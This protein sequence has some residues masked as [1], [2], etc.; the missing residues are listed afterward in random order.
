MRLEL[1]E[2]QVAIRDGLERLFADV[3]READPAQAK[4]RL[5]RHLAEMGWLSLSASIERGGS[6]NASLEVGL[7]MRAA[8][9]HALVTPYFSSLAL[10]GGVMG[11][12][13]ELDFASERFAR[14]VEGK[15]RLALAH[16]EGDDFDPASPSVTAARV[17]GAWKLSGAK[18]LSFGAADADWLIVSASLAPD[19]LFG[20]F[21][22]PATAAGVRCK[23]VGT[24]RG[25]D[26]ADLVLDVTAPTD[27]CLLQ[28]PRAKTLLSRVIDMATLAL[29]WEAVG[30]M[31]SLFEQTAAYVK[32]REQFGQP[33][34]V[35][36][37][38]QH[39][40]AEMAVLCEE[41]QSI[42]ELASLQAATDQRRRF[43]SAAKVRIAHGARF[44]AET[45]VQLHGG[46]GVT[47]ELPVARY[48]RILLGFQVALG[49]SDQ[50]LGRYAA[51]TLSTKAHTKSAVLG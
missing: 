21:L 23:R 25:E 26:A 18:D 37:T 2:D 10:G 6:P 19:G 41:A 43:T 5:W 1:S 40:L 49:T 46:V 13:S 50:H 27:A 12:L 33:I 24:L 29:C 34:A 31:V 32:I 9:R 44:V 38:V 51:E 30:A 17:D 3:A 39:R 15:E 42:A 20:L 35:F 48:F 11:A 4:A 36:Q 16:Q 22:I 7:L 8:G 47:E 45:A 28:G 14:A